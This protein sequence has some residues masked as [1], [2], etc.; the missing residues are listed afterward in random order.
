[1]R[2]DFWYSTSFTTNI[3]E[4]AHAF[5]Q[6]EGKHLSLIAAIQKA[7]D[8][9]ERFLQTRNAAV[10]FAVMSNWGDRSLASGH[11]SGFA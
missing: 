1:M 9:D 5:G 11:D 6:G 4:S 3:G 10:N 2:R 8:M 7:K